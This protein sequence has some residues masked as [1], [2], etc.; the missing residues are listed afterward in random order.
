MINIV[1]FLQFL[2]VFILFGASQISVAQSSPQF[3]QG[4]DTLVAYTDVPGLEPSEF[5]NIR[6]RSA[7]TN[8]EWVDCFANITRNRAY[9][10]EPHPK[11]DNRLYHLHTDGWSHTYANIEMSKNS[12]VEVEISPKNGFKINGQDFFKSAVHPSH[13]ANTASVVEGKVYFTLNNPASITVDINGQMD[14]YQIISQVPETKVT[15]PNRP[16]VHTITIFAHPIMDKP[17]LD[18][19]NVVFVEPGLMPS[20]DL[21]SETILYFKPGVHD[22]GLGFKLQPG[23][24]YYIPGDAVVYGTM[25]NI[26]VAGSG[27]LASGENIKIFGVGTISGDKLNHPNFDFVYDPSSDE[28]KPY[29]PISIDNANYSGVEGICLAN[30]AFHSAYINGTD[31]Y[32]KWAKAI[33]W[34]GNGDG[35]GNVYLTEDC[36]LRTADDC[37]YIKGNKRRCV[38]W[39]D[40]NAAVFHM[41]NI[42]ED[43][44]LVIED[45]DVIYLR[46]ATN[47]SRGDGVFV[48]RTQGEKGQRGVNVLFKDIRI[49]D[50]FP[51]VPIFNLA[52][53]YVEFDDKPDNRFYGVG[54]SYKG[55]T[56]RN[57]TAVASYDAY[58]PGKSEQILGHA[59]APWYGG[60]IFDSVFIAGEQLTNLDRFKTN[61]YVEDILFR[62][63]QDFTLTTNADPNKGSIIVDPDQSEYI[64]FTRIALTAKAKPGY[65]FS[66]W[67]GDAS[68]TENPIII[69]MDGNKT[70]SANFTMAEIDKPIVVDTPGSGTWT[71]PD[72]IKLASIQVWGA[73]GAGGSAANGDIAVQT[74]GG[75]G[76]GGSYAG[77]SINVSG[78]DILTYSVGAGGVFAPEGFANQSVDLVQNGDSSF[79]ALNGVTIVSAIGGP[80][81]ENI[82]GTVGQGLGGVAPQSGNI[83][84]VV[85]YGGNGAA[86]NPGGTGGGGGSAGSEGNGGD[87]PSPLSGYAPGGAAGKGGGAAGAE[88]FNKTLE[89]NNGLSPGAGGSGAAVRVTLNTAK[90]GGLGSDGKLII[91]LIPNTVDLTTE[92]V[93]GSIT[94]SPPG[95]VYDYETV[96]IL[97]AIPDSGY[98]FNGWSGDLSGNDNPDS[99]IMDSYKTVTAIITQIP[100]YTLTLNATN[101]AINPDP[102]G[103]T[104]SEGTVVTLTPI[105]D[106]GYEFLEW[107]GD[108]TGSENPTTITMDAVKNI[109]AVFNEVTSVY[110]KSYN[111][112]LITM[113][114]E[115]YPN[116]FSLNTTIPYRLSEATSVKLSIYNSL[117]QIV[118]VLVNE[119]QEAGQYK[120]VWYPRDKTGNPLPKGI[121]ICQLETNNYLVQTKKIVFLEL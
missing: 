73:G 102:V 84:D 19:P 65:A 5:Y 20:S 80:G 42:P 99:I 22:I 79:V 21:G 121:Y 55:I 33:T 66:E 12:G 108:I 75:G 78:G 41:P 104:Y 3:I 114:E 105:P 11:G 76:A 120:V 2:C 53:H 34:R 62:M 23:K 100:S 32:C 39:K 116:P 58:G 68:G 119:Y 51:N 59:E 1:V 28:Q 109:T 57:I 91:T 110:S 43:D 52:S 106:S 13:K 46:S 71:L 89:G 29:K 15:D 9:L 90:S 16:R 38:F 107:N 93:N 92:V 98:Q 69:K 7:A 17:S 31:S 50:K 82:S 101:G 72:G 112:S 111:T 83:G 37:S 47:A 35:F 44:S 81:G 103:S 63:P 8:Y 113:L 67:S 97:T 61:Q 94:L 24:K 36:F 117:G 85:F 40:S 6:V 48:Q 45:C 115:I 77:I 60:V 4:S 54:S 74:R 70:I 14:D 30:G 96:V 88:G 87:A 26:G 10:Q 86:A 56:F 25:N 95:G 64:E 27:S 118:S 18:D 49:H